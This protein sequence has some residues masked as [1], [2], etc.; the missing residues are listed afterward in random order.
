[1]DPMPAAPTLHA[2]LSAQASHVAPTRAAAGLPIDRRMALLGSLFSLVAC[3]GGG[4]PAPAPV[5]GPPAP[6]APALPPFPPPPTTP[7]TVAGNAWLGLGGNGQHS[8]IGQVATQ[9]LRTLIWSTAVDQA[10][11][12]RSDGALLAHYGSPAITRN[13]TVLLAV[14]NPSGV[15]R[16]EARTG[17]NGNLLWT[18]DSTYRLPAHNWVPPV[19]VSLAPDGGRAFLPTAGGR[20]LER[21]TPD[22]TAGALR[23]LVF[24][25]EAA[26]NAAAN[27]YDSGVFINTPL[28]C[29]RAGNLYFGFAVTGTNPAGLSGGIARIA[30]D[31][32]GSWV[33]ASVAAAD[34]TMTRAAMN[35]AP[36]L[37]NDETVVY[38]VVSSAGTAGALVALDAA[39]LTPRARIALLDPLLGTPANVTS[40]SSGGPLVAPNGDVF[41]G[42]LEASLPS[43][44]Y[45]GWLLHF[46]AGLTR[47]LTP[48]SFGW[49][50][51][52]SIVPRAMV[53]QYTGSSSYLVASKYNSY[54]GIGSGDGQH[55]VAILDPQATQTDRFVNLPVM[56]EIITVLGPSPSLDYPGGVQEWCINTAAVDPATQSILMNS[57]DGKLYRWHLP[58]NTLSENI[59]L[60]NGYA[61][62]YTPTAIGPDGRVYAINNARLFCVGT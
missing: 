58:T 1:M 55:R 20:V 51:T 9:A 21:T 25:G 5:A 12:Y 34:A 19:N 40:D 47:A 52:P 29:D 43:H 41:F 32:T 59:V 4:S 3:G 57:E 11:P 49:D 46:D 39:T 62:A 61:Q 37:S 53:P 45:R 18:L 31:G 17:A 28:T 24:Y 35:A 54:G 7:A 42:V 33:A 13:N 60:N 44:N 8:A 2:R 26:Y 48:G 6:P 16:M 50:S 30:A 15:W 38:A 10:P 36:A 56:K 23:T 14:K 27:T 22:A